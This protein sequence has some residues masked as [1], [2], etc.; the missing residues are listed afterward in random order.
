MSPAFRNFDASPAD[1][2]DTWPHE[3]LVA[4]IERG[5]IGD[6]ARIT[7]LFER[8]VRRAR[9]RADQ[10]DRAAVAR[11][12]R[13][14]VERSGLTRSE[15]ASRSGTSASRLSTYLSGF[16]VP[17]AALLHRM[18]RVSRATGPSVDR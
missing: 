16:V 10:A 5:T 15:F 18:E 6:W 12:L 9:A 1:A 14:L 2:V 4:A 3:A 8:A 17:S 13:E 7:A 11:R